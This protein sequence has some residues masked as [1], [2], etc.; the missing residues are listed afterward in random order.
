VQ[1]GSLVRVRQRSELLLQF[2]PGLTIIRGNDQSKTV[3]TVPVAIVPAGLDHAAQ[4]L[5]DCPPVVSGHDDDEQ[6]P[7]DFINGVCRA[8]K[9][10]L[11]G[12]TDVVEYVLG[13][14]ASQRIADKM[15]DC[16]ML[17]AFVIHLQ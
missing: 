15:P 2:A 8:E 10:A 17:S 7:A 9:T 3:V 16:L 11:L 4:A 12:D 14:A 1:M 13:T 6:T 5:P